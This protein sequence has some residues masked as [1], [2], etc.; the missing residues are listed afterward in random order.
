LSFFG[1]LQA[2]KLTTGSLNIRGSHKRISPSLE[3][4]ISLRFP[5]EDSP[6]RLEKSDNPIT[7]FSSSRDDIVRR[8]LSGNL[9]S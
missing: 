5:S 9:G 1:K 7:G 4:A 6:A 8:D 2:L 3:P